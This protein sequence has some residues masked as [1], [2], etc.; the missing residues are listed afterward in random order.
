MTT[1][2][3]GTLRDDGASAYYAGGQLRLRAQPEL[4]TRVRDAVAARVETMR[5]P[6]V[7]PMMQPGQCDA[8]GGELDGM[9]A[10][11]WCPLCTVARGLVLR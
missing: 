10:G 7:L 3:W 1:E 2:T 11:G 8:C 5:R 6:V 9:A 4:Q